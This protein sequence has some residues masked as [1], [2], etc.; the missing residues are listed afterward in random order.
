MRSRDRDSSTAGAP[1]VSRS[2][3]GEVHAHDTIP[4]GRS[5]FGGPGKAIESR[6]DAWLVESRTRKR[7]NQLCIQQSTGDSTS[8]EVDISEGAV[9]QRFANDN[10][11]D[12][13]ASTRLQN[14][15][16]LCDSCR[17]VGDEIQH[18]I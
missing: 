5:L 6:H 18:A 9:G 7:V 3:R 13:R 4:S 8:P 10:V 17:L 15:S 1:L 2:N 16:D 12:L 11:C 14:S